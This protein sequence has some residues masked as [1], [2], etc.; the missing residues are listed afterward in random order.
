MER[1]GFSAAEQ[2]LVCKANLIAQ[3]RVDS[4]VLILASRPRAQVH[5]HIYIY[6]YMYIYIYVYICIDR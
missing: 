4:V 3:G 5:T 2:Q 1:L 6:I